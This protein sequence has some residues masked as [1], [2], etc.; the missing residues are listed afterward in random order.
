MP[1]LSFE[2]SCSFSEQSLTLSK[3][4]NDRCPDKNQ[5][6]VELWSSEIFRV[7][8]LTLHQ[9]GDQVD[10]RAHWLKKFEALLPA[11]HYC[12]NQIQA[13]Q[14]YNHHLASTGSLEHLTVVRQSLDFSPGRINLVANAGQRLGFLIIISDST[15][16]CHNLLA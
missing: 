7:H 13:F 10:L 6:K 11:Q 2:I 12:L 8:L 5:L 4:A 1:K 3:Q 16:E 15:L 14:N 9:T